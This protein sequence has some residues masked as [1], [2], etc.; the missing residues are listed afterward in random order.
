M[1]F[2]VGARRSGTNWLHTLMALH[3]RLVNVPSETHLFYTLAELQKRFQH[4]LLSSPNTGATYLPRAELIASFRQLC[5]RA[6][7]F[8]LGADAAHD[9]MLVERTPL[10]AQHLDLIAEIYPDAAVVHLIRDGRDVAASLARQPWGP[11]SIADAAQEWVDTVGKARA[12][13]APRYIEIRHEDLMRDVVDTMRALFDFLGLDLPDDM[14][15]KLQAAARIPVNRSPQQHTPEEANDRQEVERIAGPLLAELGYPI[16]ESRG[17]PKPSRRVASRGKRSRAEPT[18]DD[19]QYV[20]DRL[21]AGLVEQDAVAL[22]QI[23]SPSVA[24]RFRDTGV[25]LRGQDGV[26]EVARELV[27]AIR[28][29]GQQVRGDSFGNRPFTVVWGHEENGEVTHRILIVGVNRERLV[30]SI[31]YYE[32]RSS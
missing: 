7:A 21:L 17:Q 22:G 29:A 13:R 31:D 14:A 5:D 15:G 28:P 32:M 8:Q 3:P 16:G 6:F 2:L 24:V 10:H 18:G 4:G 20:V 11:E 27:A 19:L 1:V 23:L 25:E 9:V 30:A 26:D 12:H